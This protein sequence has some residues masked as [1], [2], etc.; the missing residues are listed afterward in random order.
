MV[1][2]KLYS[3]VYSE[4]RNLGVKKKYY[5]FILG[6]F[7]D[8]RGTIEDH[9]YLGKKLYNKDTGKTYTIDK[10]FL[11]WYGGYYYSL[12]AYDENGSHTV[13][14]FANVNS[15]NDIIKEAVQEFENN[16]KVF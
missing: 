14:T 11:H 7:L 2:E 13:L 12:T 5:S 4:R 15:Q 10:V 8:E 3:R 6:K 9:E 1:D 16:C